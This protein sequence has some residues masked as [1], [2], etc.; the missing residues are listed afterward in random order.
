[1]TSAPAATSLLEDYSALID[2]ALVSAFLENVPDL[3]YFKDRDSRFIA[4]SQS[5]ALRHG[6]TDR[7]ALAGKRHVDV[8]A[9]DRAAGREV[10]VSGAGA[11]RGS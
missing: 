11:G 5:K 8:V 10:R 6:V 2:R 1:M 9:Y 7:A 3:V 4:V